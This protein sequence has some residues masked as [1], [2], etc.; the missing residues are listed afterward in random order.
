M[1]SYSSFEIDIL[2]V[3]LWVGT[4]SLAF[5]LLL[6]PVV[7][8]L[9]ARLL[10]RER[11]RRK[12]LSVWQPILMNS[13]EVPSVDV[14]RLARRDLSNFLLLWNHLHES[15]LDESKDHLNQIA[16]AL[17]IDRIALKML[18]RRNLRG[19]LLA[20][21]TLGQLRER[22]AWDELSRITQNGDA[23]SSVAAARAL[24]LIDPEKAI[25]QLISLLTSRSDWTVARVASVLQTAGADIISDPIAS[26][27]I[28]FSLADTTKRAD[29]PEPINH[30]ARLVRYLQLTHSNSALTAARTIAGS[31]RDPEVL[32]ASL[33]LLNS[34][35][36]L[37]IIRSCLKHEAW[38]VRVQAA[39][40]LGRVG[41]PEDERRLI[42]LLSDK[43]W[44]VRYR[45]AQALSRLPS[46]HGPR[47]KSIRVKQPDPFARDMLAH[48]IAEIELQ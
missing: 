43:Q 15:L 33:Q 21:V 46:M 44:W 11:R 22:G 27:A 14:P 16:Y 32:A 31:S 45:A 42:A 47:L 41:E 39:G 3:A 36:D 29:Q 8:I 10:M 20:T 24:V 37:E 12:F 4:A 30:A 1:G 9:R 13:I 23:I 18:R 48:V 40:A 17:S 6:S 28:A 19:R 26:A 7:F 34:A 2:R 38:P 35:E 25:P 5:A